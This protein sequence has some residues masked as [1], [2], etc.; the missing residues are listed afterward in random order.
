MIPGPYSLLIYRGDTYAWLFEIWQDQHRRYPANLLGSKAKAEIRDTPG[1]RLRAQMDCEVQLPN[2]IIVTLSA[3][4][5]EELLQDAGVWDL[6]ITQ[7]S[8]VTTIV[9]GPVTIV[10]DVTDSRFIDQL[11]ASPL[12]LSAP[13]KQ[14]RLPAPQMR[15]LAR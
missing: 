5:S 1:G 10:G 7:I 12:M 9:R 15:G 3:R 8:T 13:V 2:R 11:G 14:M 4:Q 6:Q